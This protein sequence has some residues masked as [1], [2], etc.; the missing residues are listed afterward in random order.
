MSQLLG[1]KTIR[2]ICNIAICFQVEKKNDENV[3]TKLIRTVDSKF[4]KIQKSWH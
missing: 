1:R 4:M 2:L 3:Y